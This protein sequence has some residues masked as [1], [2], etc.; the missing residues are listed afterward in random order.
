MSHAEPLLWVLLLP[1]FSPPDSA[2]TLHPHQ[3]WCNLSPTPNLSPALPATATVTKY[4]KSSG[5]KQELTLSQFWR[6]E[7]RNQGVH[8]AVFS[9]G[10]REN[11]FPLLLDSGGCWHS[12]EFLACH[13]IPPISVFT[14]PPLLCLLCVL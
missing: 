8:R 11:P 3:Q 6:P 13:C 2:P 1:L 4:H 9:K 10:S 14:W 12:L 5:S 7:I